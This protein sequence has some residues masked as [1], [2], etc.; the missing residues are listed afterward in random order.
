MKRCVLLLH[1]GLLAQS[2][3]V[4]ACLFQLGSSCEYGTHP[5]DGLAV[6]IVGDLTHPFCIPAD[7]L[8]VGPRV[9]RP[10]GIDVQVGIIVLTGY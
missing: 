2:V 9:M 6:D 8:P 10:I 7:T 4:D 1:V 3:W 5:V